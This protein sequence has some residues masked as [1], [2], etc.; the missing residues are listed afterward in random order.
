VRYNEPGGQVIVSTSIVSTSIVSNS[1]VAGG[2]GESAVLLRVKDTGIGMNE[3]ELRAALEPFRQSSSKPGGTGLGLPLTRALAEAN[4]ADFKIRS[5]KGEGTL[6]EVGFP[7]ASEAD[8]AG[9]GRS[10]ALGPDADP[11]RAIEKASR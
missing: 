5:R 2:A 6:V 4:R 7:I 11:F 3:A 8:A 9:A 10:E 1:V